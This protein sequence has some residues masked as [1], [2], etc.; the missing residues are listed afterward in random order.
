MP[1]AQNAHGKQQAKIGQIKNYYV[2]PISL[3][4]DCPA[5]SPISS[6]DPEHISQNII[7]TSNIPNSMNNSGSSANIIESIEYETHPAAPLELV[8]TR[9]SVV[10]VLDSDSFS[11]V[12]SNSSLRQI[13]PTLGSIQDSIASR[14]AVHPS[15][16]GDSRFEHLKRSFCKLNEE[17]LWHTR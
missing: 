10:N 12:S 8:E 6:I 9:T 11:N 7:N 3:S 2:K 16:I 13:S 14:S 1:L 17:E 4:L 15:G 5:T